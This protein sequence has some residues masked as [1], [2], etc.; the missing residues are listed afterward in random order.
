MSFKPLRRGIKHR[1]AAPGGRPAYGATA[2]VS[3]Y[4]ADGAQRLGI[5]RTLLAH[6]ENLAPELGLTSL[7]GF[8]FD[9][10]TP[11]ISLFSGFGFTEWGHLP[12]VAML[13]GISR[14]V[15]ILGK[16]LRSVEEQLQG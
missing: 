4:V 1:L 13:D 14:G 15:L 11:S 12:D 16:R 9:H 3:I 5:G 2:E 6:A 8:I 10:N 7:L